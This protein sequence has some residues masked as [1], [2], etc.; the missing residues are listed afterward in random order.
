MTREAGTTVTGFP[1]PST[2]GWAARA[3]DGAFAPCRRVARSLRCVRPASSRSPG[4]RR[5]ASSLKGDTTDERRC[6]SGGQLLSAVIEPAVTGNGAGAPP[7][8]PRKTS[9]RRQRGQGV[10]RLYRATR[11]T[12]A[13][14]PLPSALEPQLHVDV[15]A[16]LTGYLVLLF[17]VPS[18]LVVAGI[19][20]SVTPAALVGLGALGWWLIARMLPESGLMGGFQPVHVPLA[21]FGASVLASYAAAFSRHLEGSEL[22]AA[23]RGLFQFALLAGLTLLVA[24]GVRSQDQLDRLLR[25]LV[26]GAGF[27]AAL[28]I[29]QFP[30]GLDL[31]PLL[32]LPGLEIDWGLVGIGSRSDF[33]RVHSTAAHPLEFGTVLTMVL[34]LALH[35]ALR[36]V[37]HRPRWRRWW[38]VVTTAM[39]IPMSIS[40]TAFLGLAAIA[41]VLVPAWPRRRQLWS[42]AAVPAFAVLMQLAIPGLLGTIRGLFVFLWSDSSTQARIQDYEHVSRL[43]SERPLLG[44][45]F[46]TF[47]PADN[48]ILDNQYLGTVVETGLVGLAAVLLLFL[49]SFFTARGAR[50][51]SRDPW[52]RDL[53]QSLAAG[54]V[55]AAVAFATFDVLSFPMVTGILFLLLGCAGAQWRIARAGETDRTL[56]ASPRSGLGEPSSSHHDEH[57]APD[58]EGDDGPE[59]MALARILLQRWYVVVP[60]LLLTAVA[61]FYVDRNVE[62][63]Y[64]AEGKLL[65]IWPS[66][67]DKPSNPYLNLHES[68]GVAAEAAREALTRP[69]VASRLEEAGATALY[70]VKVTANPPMLTVT[71]EGPDSEES[72]HT[73]RLVVEELQH[74]LEER[75][76]AA[77]APAGLIIRSQVLSM[78]QQAVVRMARKV[79]VLVAV[80][81]LGLAA[82]AWLVAATESIAASRRRARSRAGPPEPEAPAGGEGRHGVTVAHPQPRTRPLEV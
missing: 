63:S 57:E 65:L 29:F 71:A 18:N 50:R 68:L 24:D 13:S 78:S 81:V 52:V 60:T 82:S 11:K 45:G 47:M 8:P 43:F 56:Q 19:G 48:F 46:R 61:F 44:L 51:R 10:E 16:F 1:P 59:L 76:R 73:M 74:Q 79:R 36:D 15:V 40:R 31:A 49:V 30:T 69:E 75:Q 42:A 37:G 66:T 39:A 33:H 64:E 5:A 54:F 67:R 55:V 7:P 34:P 38:P 22:R 53:S 21:C 26:M 14:T 12:Q 80:W 27:L 4:A 2:V 72:L 58:F 17:V 62:P 70:R 3:R 20:Y 23:D 9:R 77:G 41:L 25:R 32:Q 35:F 6:S 28:G